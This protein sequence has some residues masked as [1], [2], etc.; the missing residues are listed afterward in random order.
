[1]ILLTARGGYKPPE[2]TISL[3]SSLGDALVGKEQSSKSNKHNR[4]PKHEP[5]ALLRLEI[6]G[7]AL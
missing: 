6:S 2:A 5:N 1:V 7:A 3:A 4:W